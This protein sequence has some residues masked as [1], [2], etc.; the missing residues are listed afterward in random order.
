M[1]ENIRGVLA[2]FSK[3]LSHFLISASDLTYVIISGQAD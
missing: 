3:H 2:L 1:N